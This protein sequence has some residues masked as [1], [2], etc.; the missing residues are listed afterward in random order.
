MADIFEAS[1]EDF[2]IRYYNPLNLR[3]GKYSPSNKYRYEIVIRHTEGTDAN[4]LFE[5]AIK[6]TT[7]D[8]HVYIKD[9]G[10]FATCTFSG[11]ALELMQ[12]DKIELYSGCKLDI[13]PDQ[14][15]KIL[16]W[17]TTHN[18]KVESELPMII[19]KG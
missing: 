2:S 1:H 11:R 3:E 13:E 10:D 19:S 7:E 12:A 9:E 16:T 14:A 8:G 18:V 4:K 5:E 15:I 17:A 6:K